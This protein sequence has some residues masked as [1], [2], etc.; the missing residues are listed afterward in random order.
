MN[1]NNIVQQ[2]QAQRQQQAT[3]TATPMVSGRATA[4]TAAPSSSTSTSDTAT[5]TANDFITLLVA[6][7]QHQDPTSD[8]D[9]NTYVN[10][11]VNVNSLQ[12]LIAINQGV[13]TLDTV[14]TTPT[15]PTTPTTGT[16]TSGSPTGA[17]A[18]A[19]GTSAP[20]STT[21]AAQVAKAQASYAAFDPTAITDQ[22]SVAQQLDPTNPV[23]NS[24]KASWNS[25]AP[26]ALR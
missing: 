2:L 10:Q 9:P 26:S 22:L 7:L 19:S 1:L 15:T 6:E 3:G 23:V 25:A 20:S 16:P 11:L 13:G 21:S 8:T 5:I 14:A 12:Q 24:Q 17:V 4:A 18:P